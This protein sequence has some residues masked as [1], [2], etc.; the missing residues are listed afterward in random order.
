MNFLKKRNFRYGSLAVLLTV[1]VIAVVVAVNLIV[2]TLATNF[3]W[4]F[5]MTSEN[6][7]ELSDESKK[8]LDRVD[9]NSDVTVYFLTEPDRLT[10]GVQSSNYF[11]QATAWGMKPIHEIATEISAGYPFVKIEYLNYAKNPQKLREITGKDYDGIAF[12]S[13]QIIVDSVSRT[14]GT[15]GTVYDTAHNYR[16]FSRDAFYTFGEA[17]NVSSFCGDYRFA[18]A[19]G[20]LTLPNGS[21]PV[22]YF[23]TGHGEKVG[24]YDSGSTEK[25]TDYSSAQSLYQI[26]RDCGY[27]IRKID[28]KYEDFGKED[29]ALAVVY[30]PST[31]FLA[32][33]NSD[34]FNETEKLNL[35][36]KEKNHSLMVF[37][38][39]GTR[40]LSNLENFLK[41]KCGVTAVDAKVADD[42]ANAVSVDRL[43]FAGK[44]GGAS[45]ASRIAGGYAAD[46]KVIFSSVRPLI[47]DNDAKSTSAIYEVPDSVSDKQ[48]LGAAL[49]TL[50]ETESGSQIAICGTS[51]FV[52]DSYTGN[53]DYANREVMLETVAGISEAARV[54]TG[55]SFK[56]VMTDRLDITNRQAFI[57]TVVLSA[58][59]PLVFA[60][61]GIIVY[62]RRRYS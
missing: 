49:M 14:T 31:D 12:Q 39:P 6:M 8:L 1:S 43:S 35:F 53:P 58:G 27:D 60:C 51:D 5:D 4:F 26:L 7:Y 28:L 34:S 57:L 52:G 17:G 13:T 33:E 56:T 54:P 23:I 50:T 10:S 15:D 40:K 59:I 55:V 25:N 19:I 46:K 41:E 42:G 37:L 3:G 30:S 20:S 22:A 16:I 18:A 11:G 32:P 45:V 44:A 29:D 48:L 24:S 38:D 47:I 2:S 61:A 9:K 21:A 62:L 36:L